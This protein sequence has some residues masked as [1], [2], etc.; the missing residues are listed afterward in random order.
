MNGF[1]ESDESDQSKE[2]IKISDEVKPSE[3]RKKT[4]K[5]ISCF[6]SLNLFTRVRRIDADEKEM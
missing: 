5:L 3:I 1:K 6:S 4:A 2:D